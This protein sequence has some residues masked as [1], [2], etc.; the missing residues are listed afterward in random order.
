MNTFDFRTWLEGERLRRGLSFA[1]LGELV[2]LSAGYMNNLEKGTNEPTDETLVKLAQGLGL[3]PEWLLAQVDTSRIGKERIE[4][5]R[6]YAP[7]F[8]GLPAAATRSRASKKDALS[9]FQ[10]AQ[11]HKGQRV[12]Q[13]GAGRYVT[14]KA[15][16]SKQGAINVEPDRQEFDE[17]D[18]P[19]G[20]ES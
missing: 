13:D 14:P 7:E 8:L 3:E 10:E 4:R 15:A 18:E 9:T 16:A 1:K 20:E 5:I 19:F 12:A 17:L 2:G 11:K 6:K